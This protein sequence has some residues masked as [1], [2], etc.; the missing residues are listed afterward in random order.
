MKEAI[1]KYCQQNKIYAKDFSK[2]I[3]MPQSTYY[4]RLRDNSWTCKEILRL[5]ELLHASDETMLKWIK[6]MGK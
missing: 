5:A 3:G 1:R 2:C 6:D 4:L